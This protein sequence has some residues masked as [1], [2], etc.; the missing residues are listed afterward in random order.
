[1]LPKENWLSYDLITGSH[2]WRK[3]VQAFSPRMT[4]IIA[5]EK[6]VKPRLITFMVY[7]LG[8]MCIL[9]V[10]VLIGVYRE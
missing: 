9:G 2:P 1:M 3:F 5:S 10:N 7:G 4:A 6:P 8:V